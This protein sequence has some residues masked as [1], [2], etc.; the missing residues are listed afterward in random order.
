MFQKTR[1]LVLWVKK[2]L[3]GDKTPARVNRRTGL[4]KINLEEFLK[5]PVFIQIF[6]LLHELIHYKDQTTDETRCDLGALRIYL[7]MMYPKS[8]ANYAMT[9]VFDN[10]TESIRRV[11]I[12]DNFIK[13]YD[14]RNGKKPLRAA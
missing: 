6:I 8:S 12:L 7:G 9:R 1:I 11:T 4:I 3:D 5:F 13:N 10:S 2:N 14:A